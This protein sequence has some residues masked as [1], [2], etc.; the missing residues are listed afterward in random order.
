MNT[1]IWKFKLN[2]VGLQTIEMPSGAGVLS[3]Q[4]INNVTFLYAL[5]NTEAETTEER[6]F[7]V[8]GTGNT[9]G[10]DSENEYRFVGTYTVTKLSDDTTSVSTMVGHVFEVVAVESTK[11]FSSDEDDARLERLNLRSWNQFKVSED[12]DVTLKLLRAN[13]IYPDYAE[14]ILRIAFDAG[15]EA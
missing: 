2:G 12:F 14:H 4:V 9:F 8:Y 5:V 11:A 13:G 3:V 15:F 6:T 10:D 1:S 7:M